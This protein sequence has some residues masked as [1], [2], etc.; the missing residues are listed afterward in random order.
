MRGHIN[1]SHCFNIYS[2]NFKCLDIKM[3]K[4]HNFSSKSLLSRGNANK[5]DTVV[6]CY[7]RGIYGE[8]LGAH[9]G[10][11]TY[12]ASCQPESSLKGKL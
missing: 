12:P 9:G 8:L 3:N 2:T 4:E 5:V 6:K 10:T 11:L 7:V 1:S